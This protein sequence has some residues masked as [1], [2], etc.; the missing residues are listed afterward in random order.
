[1]LMVKSPILVVKSTCLMVKSQFWMVK[2]PFLI[3]LG[4]LNHGS[5]PIPSPDPSPFRQAVARLRHA[6]SLLHMVPAALER[7]YV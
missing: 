6:G 1:M 2:P 7:V 5:Y 3:I 4:W